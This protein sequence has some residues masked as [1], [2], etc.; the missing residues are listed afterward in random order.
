MHKGEVRHGSAGRLKDSEI[1]LLAV[2]PFVLSATPGSTSVYTNGHYLI[3]DTNIFL[4]CMDVLEH[5]SAFYDVV[6]LQTVLEEVRNRS[7]PLYNRL[8]S[9]VGSEEKRF[10]VFH[11]EFRQETFVQRNPGEIINDR[12]DRA[13]RVACKWYQE[14]LKESLAGTKNKI[15]TIVML[16]D[17]KENLRKA[18]EEGVEC[19][20]IAK[21]VEG[22]PNKNELLDMISAALESQEAK[23]GKGEMLYPEVSIFAL[24][25]RFTLTVLVVLFHVKDDDWHQKR[26]DAPGRLQRQHLQFLGGLNK[27]PHV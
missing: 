3:P 17:D 18:R 27:H 15:P 13:V 26:H 6:V 22:L 19:C 4:Y 9:L 11:N 16:S 21:Y 2:K 12:N 25:P 7:L 20:N 10:Y 5:K 14:H 8:R 1:N 24:I 23:V